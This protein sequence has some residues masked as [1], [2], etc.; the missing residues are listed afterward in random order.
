MSNYILNWSP[1][2]LD[3]FLLWSGVI[4]VDRL[5]VFQW[6]VAIGDN[7]VFGDYN[8]KLRKDRFVANSNIGITGVW[9]F[10]LDLSP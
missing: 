7:S 10:E 9:V 1:Q 8:S 4:Y 6:G 2:L 5:V 3:V